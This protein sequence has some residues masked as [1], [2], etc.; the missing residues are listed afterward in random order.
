MEH[1]LNCFL[2]EGMLLFLIEKAGAKEFFISVPTYF[3]LNS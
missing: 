2:S 1:F 3:N